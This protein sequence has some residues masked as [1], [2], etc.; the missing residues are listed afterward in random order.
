MT[1]CLQ[2][3]EMG[4]A[5]VAPNP[6][7]GAVL[8]H[9]NRIIG[10]GYHRQYGGPHAEVNAL[11]AV[12]DALRPLIPQS[13]LYVS[14]EPCNHQGKTPPCTD[15][16]LRQG[17]RNVVVACRDPFPDVDGRGIARLREA[18]VTVTV[19]LCEQ[20][21]RLLNRRFFT[22]H[23]RHRPYILLKWAVSEDGYLSRADGTPVK[24]SQPVTDRL[25]HRWR[26]EESA[27][28]VGYRTVCT[29]DPALTVRWVPGRH[30][31]RVVLD[32]DLS[33]PPSARIFAPEARVIVAHCRTAEDRAHISYV[34]V[35]AGNE[36]HDLLPALVQKGVSS[37]LV[38]GGAAT[39]QWFI[40]QDCW[41][42]ARVIRS[43]NIR[44]GQGVPAP[45]LT[46]RHTR[47]E[48]LPGGDSITYYKNGQS[49]T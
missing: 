38:E 32:R 41:D 40:D 30:P 22:V 5:D 10:E 39:L 46:E 37:L 43:R 24:I 26:R 27:I 45:E 28:L 21:A 20:E 29:D 11:N 33:L 8:V 15:L 44:I 3:A 14:L 1:R 9:E 31:V 17:I 4:M 19:G 2:L 25:V 49:A 7:V 12:P 13:T 16:I 35:D 36:Y 47:I 42:E 34:R 6:M 23:Q 18:G 48:E